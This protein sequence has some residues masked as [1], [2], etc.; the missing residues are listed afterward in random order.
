MCL[1]EGESF[2]SEEKKKVDELKDEQLQKVSGGSGANCPHYL[3][4]QN[5]CDLLG[6]ERPTDGSCYG[7]PVYK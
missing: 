6:S 5:R 3:S 1:S 2:M 4:G 7:C